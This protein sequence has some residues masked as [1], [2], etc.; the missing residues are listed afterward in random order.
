MITEN[1]IVTSA[2]DSTAWIKTIRSGACEHCS[3]RNSCGTAE[4]QKEMIVTVQNTLKVEKGDHV[5]IGLETGPVLFLTF[6]LYVFPII[7]L[8]IG[9]LIGN[10]IA[11]VIQMDPSIISMIFGFSF[12]GL[13]F[14]FIRKKNNS[15]S[16][17]DKYKPFI[18][19]KK[20]HIIPVNCSTP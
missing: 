11:P 16:N 15:M 4:N 2:T 12:F 3:T 1:G 20:T 8:T 6:L 19:R 13:S 14:Y 18:V 9:A 10:S 5:L 7:L 17:K